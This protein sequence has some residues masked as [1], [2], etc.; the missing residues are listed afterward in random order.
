VVGAEQPVEPGEVD[1]EVHVYRFGFQTV[2]PVMEARHHQPLAQPIEVA[3]QV[4][5][6]QRGVDV[7]H[8][9]VRLQR[10]WQ[11]AQRHHR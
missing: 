11:E 1:R 7:D 9:D 2:V 4:G 5:V 10:R 3:A 8:R 6:D